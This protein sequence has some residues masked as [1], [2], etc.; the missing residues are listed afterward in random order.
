MVVT[1]ISLSVF[2]SVGVLISL[3]ADY[4]KIQKSLPTTKGDSSIRDMDVMSSCPPTI[5]RIVTSL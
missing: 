4:K 3:K 1:M 2:D 5:F